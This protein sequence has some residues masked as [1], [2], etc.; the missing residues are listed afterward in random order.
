MAKYEIDQ[1][2]G[3]S[4]EDYY[5]MTSANPPRE[6]ADYS[7]GPLAAEAVLKPGEVVNLPASAKA[8]PPA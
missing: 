7:S 6:I 8:S 2:V 1:K 3:D 5:H 4:L